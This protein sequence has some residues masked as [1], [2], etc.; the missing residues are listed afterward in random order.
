MREIVNAIFYVLRGGIAWSL[1]PK[2]FPPAPTVYRWFARFRD[3]G[4]WERINHHL[5]MLDRER[6]CHDRGKPCENG[7]DEGFVGGVVQLRASGR[8]PRPRGRRGARPAL[9]W[10]QSHRLPAA[11]CHRERRPIERIR[12]SQERPRGQTLS[13]TLIQ[14]GSRRSNVS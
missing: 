2:D 5:E 14:P 1:L 11:D 3:D 4:T 10:R 9:A 13:S 12:L 7:A 8:W 6:A